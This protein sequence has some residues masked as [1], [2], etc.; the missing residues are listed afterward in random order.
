[1]KKFLSYIFVLISFTVAADHAPS[2]IAPRLELIGQTTS[3]TKTVDN[4]EHMI[5]IC[6]ESMRYCD[7]PSAYVVEADFVLLRWEIS[8]TYAKD[9][10][11]TYYW[12]YIASAKDTTI[13][14]YRY[15]Y[16]DTTKIVDAWRKGKVQYERL[17]YQTLAIRSFTK[18]IWTKNSK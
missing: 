16:D 5:W 6:V 7:I 4:D 13:F 9:C 8:A 1:M 10:D 12:K 18:N 14:E 2:N 3:C 11:S 17:R 15:H